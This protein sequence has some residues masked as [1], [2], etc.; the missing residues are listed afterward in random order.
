MQK[1]GAMASFWV[2]FAKKAIDWGFKV[3]CMRLESKK[4]VEA[5]RKWSTGL[6]ACTLYKAGRN[7]CPS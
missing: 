2:R 3:G 7:A 6:P 5:W 4:Q 1:I